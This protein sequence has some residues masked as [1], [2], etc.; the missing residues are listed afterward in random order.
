MSNKT[1][2]FLIIFLLLSAGLIALVPIIMFAERRHPPPPPVFVC[3]SNLKR[4]DS[5]KAVWALEARKRLEDAP[6]DTDLFGAGR[7]LPEK[8]ICP[9]GG[10]YI[11][12]KVAEK[13]RCTIPEHSL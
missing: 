11:L 4:I 9:A 10:T 2:I 13:P 8:P 5:A 1:R 7:A 6:T 12:G 3:E